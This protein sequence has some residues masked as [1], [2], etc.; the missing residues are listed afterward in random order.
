MA[1]EIDAQVYA[2]GTYAPLG[3]R[4]RTSEESTGPELLAEISEQTGG[5]IF[6]W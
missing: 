3:V 6:Q 2:L 1:R 5:R 4:R